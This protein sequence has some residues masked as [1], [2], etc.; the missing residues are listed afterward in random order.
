M[1]EL[2]NTEE[3]LAIELVERVLDLP[4]EEQRSIIADAPD[5]SEAVKARSLE[6]L[7]RAEQP[8]RRRWTGGAAPYADGLVDLPDRI[9]AYSLSQEIGRG[10]MGVV[11]KGTRDTGDFEHEV[12]IKM[13]LSGA[14]SARMVDR[15]RYERQT[16]AGLN[17][18]GIARLF[19]GG[20]TEDD[21]PYLIMELVEGK[22]LQRWLEED[23]P[24]RPAR[25]AVLG[26][27]CDALQYAHARLVI[28]RD[29]TPENV[30]IDENGTAK[31]IDFG[32]SSLQS[33]RGG[34][35]S[36]NAPDLITGKSGTPGFVAPEHG[37]DSEPG[38]A[39]DIF[40]LGKL[41]AV[42]FPDTSEPELQAIIRRACAEDPGARYET[43]EALAKDVA[44][45]QTGRSVAAFG[46]GA[47]YHA[48]KFIARN[49]LL[50]SAAGA[51]LAAI[52]AALVLV[53]GFYQ[54]ER[55][56][57]ALAEDRF[58]AMRDLANFQLFD[59]YDALQAQPGNTALLNQLATKSQTYLE[60]LYASGGE[61]AALRRETANA[62][63]RLAEVLGGINGQSLL[64][65]EEAREA[66]KIATKELRDLLDADATNDE[67]RLDLARA[68]NAYSYLENFASSDLSDALA[69]AREAQEVASQGKPTDALRAEIVFALM[70]QSQAL[71][72]G[73]AKEEEAFART[74]KAADEFERW[75]GASEPTQLTLYL[76]AR[77][78]SFLGELKGEKPGATPQEYRY[79]IARLREAGD[80][81]RQLD[82][83]EGAALDDYPS[84]IAR[85]HHATALV[86]AR[87]GALEE[88]LSEVAIADTR[89][90]A[91][92]DADPED[93]SILR[94]IVYSTNLR[95]EALQALGRLDE[96]I[97]IGDQL[98]ESQKKLVSANPDDLML[99][100]DLAS[101]LGLI[102]IPRY[103]VGLIEEGCALT[104]AS[105]QIVE[106]LEE[107]FP[108][109]DVDQQKREA[110]LDAPLEQYCN[111]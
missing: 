111:E 77:I 13:V 47:A 5:V 25:F 50:V 6:L 12:A 41:M 86:H 24:P 31:L 2:S 34:E 4:L 110:V 22:S 43:V 3:L 76:D 73:E 8:D 20:E 9:G 30:I 106:G 107:S 16:L 59:L 68:L 103:E 33:L 23:A 89:Y 26:Q 45:F 75:F 61:D 72:K 46:G 32:L 101:I 100:M 15:F 49:R 80:L 95:F 78:N 84:R 66:I 48:R 57:R 67:V 21:Q 65:R 92:A 102:A 109:R 17:H 1:S 88:A 18:P 85:T 60:N 42:L 53:T 70:N 96:A 55:Q 99:Q 98:A 14:L 97:E 81:F 69:L 51:S 105:L 90:K 64:R 37:P 54:S 63:L 71:R 40:A 58:D 29:L 83:I 87:N 10:G 28:H 39:L 62:Y 19:D 82:E 27:L 108:V 35:G 56:A 91:I 38:V 104:K 11:F 52:V 94:I 36:P 79:A 44:R 74:K 93:L 7:D